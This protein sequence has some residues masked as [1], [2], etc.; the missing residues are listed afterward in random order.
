MSTNATDAIVRRGATETGL[1]MSNYSNVKL[2]KAL[3]ALVKAALVKAPGW[4]DY[5]KQLSERLG[6]DWHTGTASRDELLAACDGLGV[7]VYALEKIA[8]AE[9]QDDQDDD[10][11][12]TLPTVT[13]PE[14]APAAPKVGFEGR[15]PGELVAEAIGSVSAFLAPSILEQ[16]KSGVSALAQA[17]AQGPRVVVETKTIR[18]NVDAGDG[19]ALPAPSIVNQVRARQYFN[20]AS[21][22][23]GQTWSRVFD[24]LALPIYDS[25]DAPAVVRDFDWQP[26]TAAAFAACAAQGTNLWLAGPAGTGKSEAARQFAALGKR[27]FVRIAI[28]RTTEPTDLIGQ[29]LPKS[30]GGFV[31]KD[32]PLTRAFRIPGCVILVDEPSFLRPGSLAV[33]Q[34][35]LDMGTI[36]LATG[37]VVERAPGV[38][39]VAADNTEGAGDETGRYADTAAMSLALIDRFSLMVSCDYLPEARE[40]A[41]LCSRAGVQIGIARHMVAYANLT[42]KGSQDGKL[43]AGLTFRRLLAW[44]QNCKVGLPSKTAFA[45]AVITPADPADR[46]TLKQLEAA[47]GGHDR[48]DQALAAGTEFGATQVGTAATAQGARAAEMFAGVSNPNI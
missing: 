28:N 2:S 22:E 35:V 9:A 45:M 21:R 17:A 48:I 32:G 37:E 26:E 41:L 14:T 18:V 44:A 34:T 27:P 7:D 16:L 29:Y 42:R 43:T 47:H 12:E 38:F 1:T 39:I 31:W 6:K 13:A 4:D 24:S 19:E 30:G 46:E 23:G 8:N 20:L 3:R 5:R 25:A 11:G 15:D 33:F 40:A 10:Q 36:Y